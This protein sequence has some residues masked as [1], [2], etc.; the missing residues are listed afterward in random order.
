MYIT[1]IFLTNII[2]NLSY[3]FKEWYRDRS[4]GLVYGVWLSED[5]QLVRPISLITE[6]MV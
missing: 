2:S 4:K 5:E 3:S 6:A 1:Y